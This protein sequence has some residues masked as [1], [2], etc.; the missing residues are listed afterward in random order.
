MVYSDFTLTEIKK[1]FLLTVDEQTSLFSEVPSQECLAEMVAALKFNA[2]N[3]LAPEPVFGAVTTGIQWRF[4][5][6]E[7]TQAQ[8]DCV[9]YSIQ[10]PE[11]VFGILRHI[12]LGNFV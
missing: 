2:S 4:L 12:A 7:A 1:R 11:K 5:R 9:E 10:N 6:L 3:G 8:V